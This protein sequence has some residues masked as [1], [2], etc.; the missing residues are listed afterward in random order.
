MAM[1]YPAK[2]GSEIVVSTAD[3][4]HYTDEM[5]G[6][7]A[8]LA[9]Y[10]EFYSD[11]EGTIPVTPTAGTVTISGS[12]LGNNYLD[13]GVIQATQAGTP[14]STYEPVLFYGMVIRGRIKFAGITGAAYARVVYW[15][16]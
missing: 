8:L 15:C 3:G 9:A 11:A 7:E 10:V 2:S 5:S 6:N 16:D 12:P 13:F 1:L 4:V 14:N